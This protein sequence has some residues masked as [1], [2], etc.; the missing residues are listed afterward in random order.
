MKS[1]VE[2]FP[3]TSWDL[4]DGSKLTKGDCNHLLIFVQVQLIFVQVVGWARRRSMRATSLAILSFLPILAA[5][6]AT[7]K[8]LRGT[9]RAVNPEQGW[10]ALVPDRD[11]GT[12]Y[13]PDPPL[14]EAFRRD[15]LRVVFSGKLKNLPDGERR[16]G[17]PLTVTRIEL[18]KVPK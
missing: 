2:L 7:L 6:G 8:N 10:Y 13:A 14:A 12:R 1:P 5:P 9:V 15:G 17:T 3:G 11:P 18:E 4:S 16:W